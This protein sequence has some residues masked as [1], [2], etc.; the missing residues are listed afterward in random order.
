MMS[1]FSRPPKLWETSQDVKRSTGKEGQE[2]AIPV[3]DPA[4]SQLRACEECPC[5]GLASPS[6]LLK[7]LD[8]RPAT[9][10]TRFWLC[11]E[12]GSLLSSCFPEPVHTTQG[13]EGIPGKLW[14]CLRKG[15]GHS[16]IP[17][18]LFFFSFFS[19][20]SLPASGDTKVSVKV[21]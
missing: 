18:F 17:Y 7:K 21:S 3:A 2:E 6:L 12:E 19:P 13:L 11:E 10:S 8:R 9:L 1:I 14:R 4:A 16:K 20:Q 15:D 5:G